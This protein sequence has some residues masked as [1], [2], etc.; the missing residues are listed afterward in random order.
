MG[1]EPGWCGLS[2]HLADI[3]AP[4]FYHEVEIPEAEA[5][6]AVDGAGRVLDFGREFLTRLR[7][8]GSA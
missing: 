2:A 4:A 5:R 7:G 6:G 8:P 3:R 1:R